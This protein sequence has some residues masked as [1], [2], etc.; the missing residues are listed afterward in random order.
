VPLT[1]AQREPWVLALVKVLQRFARQGNSTVLAFSGLRATHRQR[2]RESGVPIRFVFLCV[3]PA[4]IEARLE[5]RSGHYMLATLLASQFEALEAPTAEPDVLAV[6]G[7]GSPAQVLT[8]VV[9]A[10]EAPV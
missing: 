6:D 8:R 9:A 3:A 4:L 2:L 10:L 7:D 5:R 1:D